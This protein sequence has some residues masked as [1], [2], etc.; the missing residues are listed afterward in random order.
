MRTV[1]T[2]LHDAAFDMVIVGAGIHG[3]AIAREAAVLGARPLLVD[4]GDVQVDADASR[5]PLIDS[6]LQGVGCSSIGAV[7]EERRERE[8]L[9][10]AAPHLARPLPTLVPFFGGGARAR[11]AQRWGAWA[12]ARVGGRSTLPR[13]EVLSA[14][15]AV[16]A[17][18]GLRSDGLR[19]A[20][21]VFDVR[22]EDA[23]LTLANLQDAVDAGATFSS[24]ARVAG[25]T[26]RGVTLR[27]NGDAV[28]VRASV[29]VNAAGAA[30]D[31]VRRTLEVEG[32]ELVRTRRRRRTVLPARAGE[33]ALCAF[34]PDDRAH[35]LVPFEGGTLCGADDVDERA[36]ASE[37]ESAPAVDLEALLAS[38]PDTQAR[39][40]TRTGLRVLPADPSLPEGGLVTERIRCGQL[41]SLVAG[42][43]RTHRSTAERAVSKIM[44]APRSSTR[45]RPLAGGAGPREVDDPLWW[46]H[47][48]A[49]SRLRYLARREPS[50]GAPLCEHRP[51]LAVEL[52]YAAQAQGAVTFADAMLRRL[53]DVRGPCL[54]PA[55]LARALEVF[56]QAGGHAPDRDA[57]IRAVIE[58][59][60]AG[61]GDS[62]ATC[63]VHP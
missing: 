43:F 52:V 35:F 59:A 23:R 16:A 63:E 53:V 34:L 44:V 6:T 57:A 14:S 17:F 61:Q 11:W 49:V 9:L 18:P 37:V 2:Q 24:Y 31:S 46:R 25:C 30:L 45:L 5:S 7:R 60:R 51:F 4:A 39:C 20:L 15:D 10:R 56:E 22:T 42:R 41:H 40:I 26:E 36:S 50:L 8:R 38:G 55:C 13:P 47:G 19:S 54:Q 29:V 21:Q 58:Q 48:A 62:D 12:S 1:L 27:A 32:R 33:L 28:T 3:A